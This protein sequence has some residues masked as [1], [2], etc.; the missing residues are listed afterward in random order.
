MGAADTDR[1][2]ELG[3]QAQEKYYASRRA[4]IEFSAGRHRKTEIAGE[5]Q[6]TGMGGGFGGPSLFATAEG[7]VRSN[8]QSTRPE[9]CE[10]GGVGFQPCRPSRKRAI[11]AKA[12]F[13]AGC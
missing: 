2:R 12:H 6:G 8:R 5:I 13:I 9:L 4:L 1:T 3:A 10:I 7:A 11:G